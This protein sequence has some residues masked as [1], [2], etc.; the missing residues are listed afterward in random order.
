MRYISIIS[1]VALALSGCAKQEFDKTVWTERGNA[2]LTPFKTELMAALK[3]G[4]EDG[5]EAAIDV[6]QRVAPGIAEE[7]SVAGV[8]LGRTSHKLRNEQ[9]APRAWVRPLMEGYLASPGKAVPEVVQIENG[10]VGYVEPIF[11]KGM[12]LTCHGSAVPADVASRI[13]ERY[14]NDQARGFE[15]GDF[16]GLFWVEFSE[17]TKD[18]S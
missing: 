8:E 6:C 13:D 15:E 4:M 3:Q 14:P 17:D 9:N 11:V 1:I 7:L 12:C 10:K 2:V 5:P 16:R 18:P